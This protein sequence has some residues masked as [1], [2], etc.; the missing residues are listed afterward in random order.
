MAHN[1]ALVTRSGAPNVALV[2]RAAASVAPTILTTALPQGRV[3]VAYSQTI[4]V[5][6]TPPI[7]VGVASGQLPA[8]LEVDEAARWIHG[9]PLAPEKA[10]FEIQATGNT[11]SASKALSLVVAN[12]GSWFSLPTITTINLDGDEQEELLQGSTVDRTVTYL[13]E[14]GL[15]IQNLMGVAATSDASVATAE[16]LDVSDANGNAI[17]RITAVAGGSAAVHMEIDGV[18]SPEVLMSVTALSVPVVQSQVMPAA[19][20]GVAYSFQLLASGNPPPTWALQSGSLPPGLT[21]SS[22]GLISGTPTGSTAQIYNF[23]VA[24]TNIQGTGTAA[25]SITLSVVMQAPVIVTTALPTGNSG[26][27]YSATLE[28]TGGAPFTWEIV[29]ALPPGLT[30]SGNV[31]SGVP[32]EASDFTFTVKVS[33]A[34][35]SATRQFTLSIGAPVG[36]KIVITTVHPDV[37]TAE[38]VRGEVFLPPSEGEITGG[39]RV[40]QFSGRQFVSIAGGQSTQLVLMVDEFDGNHVLMPGDKPM[41]YIEGPG[42]EDDATHIFEVEVTQ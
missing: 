23:V 20:A 36:R 10:D 31:I 28:A 11:A 26:Q 12:E 4:Q 21:L 8:G 39:V 35:D 29:G 3:G 40:G 14:A 18:L 7:S 32:T 41:I 6:G 1:V 27:P 19:T 17:V 25:R 33:N 30:L 16:Q 15:P 38:S 24:A 5:S 42:L 13:D 34:K 2:D 22:D 37:L 9:T